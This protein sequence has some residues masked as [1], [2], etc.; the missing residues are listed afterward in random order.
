MWPGNWLIIYSKLNEE[1]KV[2]EVPLAEH[3]SDIK[4][5]ACTKNPSVIC[6]QGL[7]F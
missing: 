4:I 7:C 2:Y 3:D 6:N 1:M 5:K